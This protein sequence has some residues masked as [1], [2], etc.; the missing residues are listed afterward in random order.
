MLKILVLGGS[1]LIGRKIL[2]K[3][4]NQFD[5]ISTHS[6]NPLLN[7]TYS[8]KVSLPDDFV[9][10]KNLIEKENP[11]VVINTMAYSNLDFCEDHKKDAFSLHVEMTKKI[12]SICSNV[13]S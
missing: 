5:M 8:V 6:N 13:Q 12:S 1:G 7:N 3:F 4:K 9:V 10:L 11:D 2:E